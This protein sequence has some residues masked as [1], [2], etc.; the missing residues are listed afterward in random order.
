MCLHL[1]H[2]PG[3]AGGAVGGA[4]GAV[5]GAGGGVGGE[6]GGDGEDIDLPNQPDQQDNPDV[7]QEDLPMNAGGVCVCV[8]VHMCVC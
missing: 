8:C 6:V 3:G 2:R 1:S 5:G 7:D 4:G